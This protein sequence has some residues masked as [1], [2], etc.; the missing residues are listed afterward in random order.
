[1]AGYLNQNGSS[2][3]SLLRF[4]QEQK[5]QTPIVPASTSVDSPIRGV[6][7]EPLKGPEDTG[8]AKVVSM[9]P[10]GAVAPKEESILPS[11]QTPGPSVAQAGIMGNADKAG[12]AA[13]ESYK[14]G[15]MTSDKTLDTATKASVNKIAARTPFGWG[16]MGGI[17]QPK[18]G[19][20]I[21][22]TPEYQKTAETFNR[23]IAN[24]SEIKTSDVGNIK[25]ENPLPSIATTLMQKVS[26]Q[27][28][29][30]SHGVKRQP[31]LYNPTAEETS[32]VLGK[33]QD[34]YDTANPEGV[35]SDIASKEKPLL[36]NAV[37]DVR[38][39][40]QKAKQDQIAQAAEP[41]PTPTPA[42]NQPQVLGV[43]TSRSSEPSKSGAAT[44]SSKAASPVVK[45]PIAPVIKPSGSSAGMKNVITVNQSKMVKQY[46]P[47]TGKFYYV[48][49]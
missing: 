16:G 2:I 31:E 19:T 22:A 38:N 24:K 29:V 14:T 7:Q 10:E 4:I 18:I 40:L 1:M 43:S 20:E 34:V 11:V 5:S 25:V 41:Q 28:P 9:R 12:L 33:I 39:M 26:Q 3:G 21:S 45:T 30:F 36:K 47:K 46:D 48:K 44:T 49:V 23:N 32:S 8:S 37:S 13:L 6:I 35:F 27:N 42:P 15:G 17:V